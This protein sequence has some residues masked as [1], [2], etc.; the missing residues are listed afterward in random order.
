MATKDDVK[1]SK[2]QSEI[3]RIKRKENLEAIGDYTA[4]WGLRGLGFTTCGVAASEYFSPELLSIVIS[5]PIQVFTVGAAF[6]GGPKV[7]AYVAKI[8]KQAEGL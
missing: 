8:L 7:L 5:D 6:I 1:S 4:F 3:R 2:N